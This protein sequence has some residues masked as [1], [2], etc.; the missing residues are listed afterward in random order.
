MV[1]MCVDTW[2]ASSESDITVVFSTRRRWKSRLLL[3]NKRAIS[4]AVNEI[5]K[6]I[7]DIPEIE[8]GR[9]NVA[10]KQRQSQT[11][12]C[13]DSLGAETNTQTA[14][15]GRRDLRSDRF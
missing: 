2:H 1:S 15:V 13:A 14:A 12:S 3:P 6:N 4:C 9:V 11:A 5:K 8:Q 7:P 10:Q